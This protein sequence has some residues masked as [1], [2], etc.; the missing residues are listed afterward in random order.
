MKEDFFTVV[1]PETVLSLI[2]RFDPVGL[3]TVPLSQAHGRVLGQDI[4]ITDNLPGFAR[5]TMDGFAVRAAA[6][7]GASE[8]NPVY[9][10]RNGQIIMGEAP[11]FVLAAGQAA[12]IPTGGMMPA[13]ADSVVII[14][15]TRLI[16]ETLLEIFKPAAPGENVIAADEDFKKGEIALGRGVRLR[17][18][19]VGLLAALGIAEVAVFRMPKIG[20]I[21][22]GDEV[23]P[24]EETPAP[25]RIRDINT[26]T[27]SALTEEAGALPKAYGIVGDNLDRLKERTAVALAECD[28]VLLS[29]GSSLG[30]RDFTLELINSLPESELLVR[31]I[32]IRPGKPT[33][34][35]RINGK[36]FW[37]LPGQVASAMV[38]F[39]VIVRPFI[40]RLAGLREP[41]RRFRKEIPA[42]AA[43][44][45]PSVSGRVDYIRVRL[46]DKEGLLLAW[47]VFGKS[48][49]LHTMT[50]ADGLII[51]DADTEGIKA[52]APV[53]V[54]L[55]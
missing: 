7:F 2:D 36:P 42:R 17:S 11:G 53:S 23:V 30:T 10:D 18:Q 40:D 19:E 5:S 6:T 21:S 52:G 26:H 38:I 32:A 3:E 1:P 45:I 49:L 25:G 28:M 8:T 50:A 44:N 41:D 54:R 33:L 22:T 43:R 55:F 46:E 48:G 14:E 15:H 24:V 47:P 35:A 20:I 9:L 13:G 29:G 16:D 4:V 34:L 12:E 37:G 39:S 31:G 27:L 51:I